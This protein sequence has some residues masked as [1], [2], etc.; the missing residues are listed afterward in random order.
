MKTPANGA[1]VASHD[2]FSAVYSVL[3]EKAGA[4]ES[5]RRDFIYHH[6]ESKQPCDE[7]RFQGKLG[8]GGKY[9][10]RYNQVSCYYEDFTPEREAII[11]KTNAGL[12]LLNKQ[13]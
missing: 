4:I 3:V 5:Y 12:S 1:K 13:I 6:A 11:K 9:W 7:W 2:L 8:F 10:R